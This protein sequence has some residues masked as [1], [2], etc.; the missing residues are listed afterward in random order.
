[1]VEFEQMVNYNFLV[2]YINLQTGIMFDNV[3]SLS[4]ALVCSCDS[5]MSA[6]WNNALVNNILNRDE[7]QSVENIFKEWKRTPTFYFEHRKELQPF[8]DLLIELGYKFK[9]EDSWMFHSGEIINISQFGKVKKILTKDELA[10][11]LKVFN[12]CY[13]TDDPQNVYGEL[14]NYLKITERVW[15]KYKDT[16]RIEYF[17]VYKG[18]QPV[19]VSSL[20]NFKDIGYISNV[21]SLREVRG[22]GFG[23]LATLFCVNQSKIRGN[24]KT[25]LATEEG[26]YPNE[27]YK[28][29]GFKTD[30]TAVGYTK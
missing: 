2:K 25:C 19:A 11:F 23:K 20:T 28:R 13:Q 1:M 6:Y 30:F 22:E 9:F 15:H 3:K 24:T 18:N 12:S 27:F 16:N 21:G 8:V 5:D 4:Y 17:M 26:T 7:L 29:I 10:I 14:G